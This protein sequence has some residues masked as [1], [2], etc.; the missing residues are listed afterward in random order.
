MFCYLMK[1]AETQ[2]NI[3]ENRSFSVIWVARW[4]SVESVRLL[5]DTLVPQGKQP[6]ECSEVNLIVGSNLE[7]IQIVNK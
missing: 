5:M 2:S 7:I 1:S 6:D 3:V 4:R